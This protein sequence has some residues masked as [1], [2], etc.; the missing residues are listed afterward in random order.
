MTLSQIY[1][2]QVHSDALELAVAQ[3]AKGCSILDEAKD[4]G[5]YR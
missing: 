2:C 1:I 3:I 4:Q 5:H